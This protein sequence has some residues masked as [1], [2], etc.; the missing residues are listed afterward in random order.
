MNA[1]FF[2]ATAPDQD[3]VDNADNTASTHAR[4]KLA[5]DRLMREAIDQAARVADAMHRLEL[6][7]ALGR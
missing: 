2:P 3:V 4:V 5:S 1:T 6:A 7:L